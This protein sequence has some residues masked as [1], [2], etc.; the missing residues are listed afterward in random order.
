VPSR[1]DRLARGTVR[2]LKNDK[3]KTVIALIQRVSQASVSV[4]GEPVAAIGAGL[5][6]LLGVEKGDQTAQA[7]KLAD[8]VINYRLFEDPAGKMNLS[9]QDIAGEMLVVSQFTL[10][11]DTRKGRRPSFSSAAE[12]QLGEQ[13]Y[14][15]YVDHTLRTLPTVQTG[16]F[17]A[18]M[19]VALVND[20]PVTFILQETPAVTAHSQSTSL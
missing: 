6:V 15:Y 8:R 16:Q 4:A 7:Q 5:L 10:A 9:L 19:Q 13:L 12:P 1:T 18:N 11:A 14:K 3:G 17:G 2:C 20:G